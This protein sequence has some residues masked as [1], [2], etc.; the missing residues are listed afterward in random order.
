MK[1]IKARIQSNGALIKE[2]RQLGVKIESVGH[3]VA[4]LAE[5]QVGAK[6]KLDA[7]FDMVGKVS[8][9]LTV[10]KDNVEFVKN[11]LKRKV[12]LDEFMA[13]ERRVAMLERKSH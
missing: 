2:I 4:L 5:G 6:K 12:D 3:N 7:T 10:V 11:S 13:L 8:E 9:D 1:K